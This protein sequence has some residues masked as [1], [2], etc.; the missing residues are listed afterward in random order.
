M[1]ILKHQQEQ[2]SYNIMANKLQAIQLNYQLC[3][4][5]FI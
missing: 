2:L 4:N 5:E 3:I 1:I